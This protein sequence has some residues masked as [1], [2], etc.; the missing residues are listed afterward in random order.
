[1]LQL[2]NEGHLEGVLALRA[3]NPKE[4]LI[5]NS[6]PWLRCEKVDIMTYRGNDYIVVVDFYSKFPKIVML[7][8]KTVHEIDVRKSLHS[9]STRER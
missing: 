5:P 7:E 8:R 2:I 4:P 3:A 9:G 1:M 6:V